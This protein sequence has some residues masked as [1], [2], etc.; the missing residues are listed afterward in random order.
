MTELSPTA[1]LALPTPTVVGL[2]K[3]W[4][5]LL[6]GLVVGHVPGVCPANPLHLPVAIQSSDRDDH[7]AAVDERG[8]RGD[9]GAGQEDRDQKH[10]DREPHEHEEPHG[11]GFGER[12]VEGDLRPEV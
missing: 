7:H 11:V 2:Q 3:L 4:A 5:R 10:G 9:D 1:I 6:V 12:E 8:K